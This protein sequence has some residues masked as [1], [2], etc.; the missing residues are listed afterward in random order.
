[1]P[2]PTKD[3]EAEP[4]KPTVRSASPTQPKWV[5]PAALVIAVIAIGVAVWTLLNPPKEKAVEL[6]AQEPA[7]SRADVC[8][9]FN[10][11]RTAVSLQTHADIGRDPA[12]VQ[13]VAAN[14]RLA[15]SSGGSYLL[16]R[17]EPATPPDLADAVR[18]FANGLQDIAINTLAGVNNQDPAQAARLKD[19]EAASNRV[20][21]LCK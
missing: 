1:M 8:A 16:A 18:A 17:L 10:T 14:A 2:K 6:T 4:V 21:D 3:E 12:A 7:E 13:A 9:A 20:A 5:A 11:V 15:M 19:T